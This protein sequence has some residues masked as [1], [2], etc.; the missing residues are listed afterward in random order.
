MASIVGVL[1]ALA[2][3]TM[4]GPAGEFGADYRAGLPAMLQTAFERCDAPGDLVVLHSVWRGSDS[5]ELIARL[6]DNEDGLREQC[7]QLPAPNGQGVQTAVQPFNPQRTHALLLIQPGSEIDRQVLHTALVNFLAGQVG[8]TRLAI[9]RWGQR[10]SQL[11]D[12]DSDAGRLATGL[13]RMAPLGSGEKPQETRDALRE[14]ARVVEQVS[15]GALTRRVVMVLS[16]VADE[17]PVP[18]GKAEVSWL[19]A[20][21]LEQSKDPFNRLLGE[22]TNRFFRVGICVAAQT[23]S[24]DDC[25]PDEIAQ[26]ARWREPQIAV[27]LTTE[28]QDFYRSR[29]D[30]LQIGTLEAIDRAKRDFT[31]TAKFPASRESQKAWVR[32]HGLSTLYCERR[33]LEV[34]VEPGRPVALSE[35]LFFTEF[36]LLSMCLDSTYLKTHLGASVC[37]AMG[38]Y[39]FE[40]EFAELLVGGETDGVYQLL[41][42]PVATGISDFAQVS[43]L[44]RRH[45]ELQPE[46]GQISG[47]D[48][49]ARYRRAFEVPD[50]LTGAPLIQHLSRHADLEQYLRWLAINSILENGDYVD[51][52]WFL[53]TRTHAADARVDT[54][55]R[56]FAWDFDALFT[57]C[58][59]ARPAAADR[60]GLLYCA[61]AALD[62]RIAKDEAL[63]ALYTQ[64]LESTLAELTPARFDEF[65][66]NSYAALSPFLDD[67]ATTARMLQFVDRSIDLNDPGQ[68][69]GQIVADRERLKQRF[70]ARRDQLIAALQRYRREDG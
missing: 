10:L 52:V 67:P 58:H 35:D 6:D 33:S 27:N 46:F 70:R 51:E 64:V 29:L 66:E 38:L 41:R 25:D 65:I 31:V 7:I 62:V 30:L 14:A 1:G 32:I 26:G 60:Y 61:E 37:A 34:R 20:T 15:P 17:Q 8:H 19:S 43:A 13:A 59:V 5:H 36:V 16:S 45:Y 28:E 4:P 40:F 2:V 48:V 24:D 54:Y 44:L 50:G 57:P 49:I 53:G 22:Q 55:F 39:P 12:F 69:R 9:Y 11:A 63:F 3:F 68:V 47:E 18:V 23:N 21:R 42:E 56:V